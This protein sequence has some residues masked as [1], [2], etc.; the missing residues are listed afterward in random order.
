MLSKL[1]MPLFGPLHPSEQ[2]PFSQVLAPVLFK[3]QGTSLPP[4]LTIFAIQN[5][6]YS[7]NLWVYSFFV[8]LTKRSTTVPK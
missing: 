8:E 4:S 6:T 3:L 1:V 7:L 2:T 5:Y